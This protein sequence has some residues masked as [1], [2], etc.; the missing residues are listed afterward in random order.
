[1]Y[2]ETNRN[3]VSCRENLRASYHKW[4]HSKKTGVEHLQRDATEQ[5]VNRI[6]FVL[7]EELIFLQTL[8]ECCESLIKEI[9]NQK[10]LQKPEK[11]I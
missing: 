8:K 10:I 7:S 3:I 11:E 9:E 5:D 1:M 4:N 6:R 2:R